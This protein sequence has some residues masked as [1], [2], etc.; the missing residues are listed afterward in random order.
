[1]S[2]TFSSAP[3]AASLRPNRGPSLENRS[4]EDWKV[5]AELAYILARHARHDMGNIYC[6]LGMFE[7]VAAIEEAGDAASLPDELQPAAV[8]AKVQAALKQIMHLSRDLVLLSQ[9]ASH[10]GYRDT[11]V[12]P[13]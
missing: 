7:I 5:H 4:A 8:R 12:V 9:A 13:L 10:S 3:I 11:R 2:A 6:T 1:M